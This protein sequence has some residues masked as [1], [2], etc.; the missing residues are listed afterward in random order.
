M[1]PLNIIFPSGRTVQVMP[2]HLWLGAALLAAFVVFLAFVAL[3]NQSV[4][5]GAAQWRA[6]QEAGVA[7]A[8]GPVV[9]PVKGA[10]FGSAPRKRSSVAG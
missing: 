2:R 4:E 6:L 1:W 9:G 7:P 5:R 8:A 3:L 10:A